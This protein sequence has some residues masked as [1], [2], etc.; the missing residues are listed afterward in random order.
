MGVRAFPPQK[1]GLGKWYPGAPHAGLV[2]RAPGAPYYRR[3]ALVPQKG[4]GLVVGGAH[5]KLG[6]VS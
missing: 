5:T 6:E 2:K 1:R 3:G 4:G